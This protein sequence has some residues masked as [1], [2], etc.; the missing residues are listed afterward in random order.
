[1]ALQI[2]EPLNKGEETRLKLYYDLWRDQKLIHTASFEAYRLVAEL[3]KVATGTIVDLGCGFASV[4]MREFYL[5]DDCAVSVFLSQGRADKVKKFVGPTGNGPGIF[6]PWR[7]FKDRMIMDT[8]LIFFNI[9]DSTKRVNYF[10]AVFK[11]YLTHKGVSILINDMHKP[12][13]FKGLQVALEGYSY[14]TFDT[15]EQ[16]EDEHGRYCQ[17]IEG[18]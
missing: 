2:G 10:P 1:M 15:L 16:T 6:M 13:V 5:D 14:K 18:A 9:S 7:E 12:A 17:L 4:V 11:K 8:T 3:C